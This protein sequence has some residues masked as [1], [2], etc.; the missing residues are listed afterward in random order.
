MIS[1]I[2]NIQKLVNPWRQKV[3]CCL[4]GLRRS[5]KDGELLFKG[6]GVFFGGRDKNVLELDRNVIVQPV[7][8]WD[9]TEV[10]ILKWLILLQSKKERGWNRSRT[11]WRYISM[12]H[13]PCARLTV[14]WLSVVK[15]LTI[16]NIST[17]SANVPAVPVRLLPL[18]S[19]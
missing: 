12:E 15:T 10:F 16:F 18:F 7:K 3:S 5:E 4:Q 13:R 11:T 9:D 19:R 17:I 8:L 14:A 6:F 1:F 2:W